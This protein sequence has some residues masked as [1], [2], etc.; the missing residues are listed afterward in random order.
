MQGLIEVIMITFILKFSFPTFIANF[1][2][3]L[4]VSLLFLM[5]ILNFSILCGN[6]RIVYGDK[7]KYLH[8]FGSGILVSFLYSFFAIFFISVLMNIQSVIRYNLKFADF[9]LDEFVDWLFV[10]TVFSIIVSIEFI[11]IMFFYE[12]F[13]GK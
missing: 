3:I 9:S 7:D 10:C 5:S 4:I 2:L 12:K 8:Y 11:L 1:G 13:N 6:L